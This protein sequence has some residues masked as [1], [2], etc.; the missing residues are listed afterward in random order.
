M[1]LPSAALP[2]AGAVGDGANRRSPSRAEL[3]RTVDRAFRGRRNEPEV[4]ALH[5]F[6]ARDPAGYAAGRLTGTEAQR[7]AILARPGSDLLGISIRLVPRASVLDVAALDDPVLTRGL[8]R[9]TVERMAAIDHAVVIRGEYRPQGFVRGLRLLQTLVAAYARQVDG[10]IL[11]PDTGE[12]WAVD[13]FTSRQLRARDRNVADQIAVVPFPDLDDASRVRLCTRGMRRFG[14]P[15]LELDALPVEPRRL[16]Q[17]TD[18][19]RGLALVVAGLAELDAAGYAS[20][21]P[22]EVALTRRDIAESLAASGTMSPCATCQE[23]VAVHL[24][25]RSRHPTDPVDHPVVRVVAPLSQSRAPAYDHP[26]WVQ[27]AI[28]RLFGPAVP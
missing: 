27:R 24:V 25:E 11:D 19:L 13:S 23:T 26:A 4:G 6:I 16:A 3:R 7:R 17:A 21:A 9:G 22:D 5:Q 28:E 8:G 14:A 12:L 20:S 2:R 15:D 1:L 18:L 10:V